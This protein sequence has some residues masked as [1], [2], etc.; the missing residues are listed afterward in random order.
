MISESV[1]NSN[2]VVK[3]VE[4]VGREREEKGERAKIGANKGRQ[5]RLQLWLIKQ[6]AGS[7]LQ[8]VEANRQPNDNDSVGLHRPHIHSHTQADRDTHTH[9]VAHATV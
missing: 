4:D 1:R 2:A 9:T 7:L 3:G 6:Q 5:Q 8:P